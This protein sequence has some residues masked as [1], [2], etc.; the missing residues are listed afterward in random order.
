M[1]CVGW[2]SG[3]CLILFSFKIVM[4]SACSSEA[5]PIQ[6]HRKMVYVPCLKAWDGGRWSPVARIVHGEAGNPCSQTLISRPHTRPCRLASPQLEIRQQSTA[7][8]PVKTGDP[9]M[10][11]L[12]LSLPRVVCSPR[13][14]GT[15]QS[16]KAAPA[17]R[18]GSEPEFAES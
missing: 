17:N 5:S 8:K 4:A 1:P 10:R 16:G 12:M 13:E 2:Q 18:S 11:C 15:R 3:F 7:L 6:L 14:S 9:P